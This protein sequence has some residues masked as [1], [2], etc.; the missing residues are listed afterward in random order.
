MVLPSIVVCPVEGGLL[1]RQRRKLELDDVEMA[2]GMGYDVECFR[3]SVL[4]MNGRQAR[5][6]PED[7]GDVVT[8][9]CERVKL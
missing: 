8:L 5:P 7:G 3:R 6:K 1:A 9:F 2:W 4:P